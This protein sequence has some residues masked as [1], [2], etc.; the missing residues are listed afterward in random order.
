MSGNQYLFLFTIGP[1]QSFIAQ[2]RKTRDLYAGSKILE[3]IIGV[4][5]KYA[6]KNYHAEIIIPDSCSDAKPNRFLAKITNDDP[7]KFAEAVENAA[8]DKWRDI[9]LQ[10]FRN[11]GVCHA[12]ETNGFDEVQKRRIDCTK[13]EQIKPA[14]AG[15]QIEDFLEVYWVMLELDDGDDY[16]EKHDEI[17]KLLAAIKNTRRFNQIDEPAARKCSLDGERNVLF[18]HPVN[19]EENNGEIEKELRKKFIQHEPANKCLYHKNLNLGEGLS[20]VSFVKRFYA[21]GEAFPSTAKVALIDVLQE[22]DESSKASYKERFQKYEYFDEQLYYEENLTSD[23]FRKRGFDDLIPDLVALEAQRKELFEGKKQPRYYALIAFDGDDMGKVWSGETLADKESLDEFQPE[24]SSLLQ[25][26]QELLAFRLG[27]YAAYATAYLDGG[28]RES[29]DG[30]PEKDIWRRVLK[31]QSYQNLI[32]RREG[33]TQ[34][35]YESRLKLSKTEKGRTVYAGGD[36]FLGFINLHY[37]FDVMN[38]LRAAYEKLVYEP[39]VEND[40]FRLKKPLTFSAGVVIAHYKEPLSIVLNEAHVAESEAKR[41]FK[42]NDKDAFAISVL[43]HSGESRKCLFK[44][45]NNDKYLTQYQDEIVSLLNE[46]KGFSNT[47]IKN[48]DKEFSS[49]IGDIDEYKV[50]DLFEVELKRLIERS[51]KRGNDK[52]VIKKMMDP[53]MSVCDSNYEYNQPFEN[54]FSAL[55]VCDFIKRKTANE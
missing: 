8:R 39:L 20:S 38:E 23:G 49:L 35:A 14:E 42:K 3:D 16:Q 36:D 13:L 4:A 48:I 40:I 1:V 27:I 7:K 10:S 37:L 28:I 29:E 41:V 51:S 32:Q 44:W 54:I 47:F 50:V 55:H 5:M 26:F 6:Q 53:V 33:E 34:E 43:K 17:Q 22:I 46:K 30:L 25:Q 21:K 15:K 9:A 2:A 31:D 18:Y 12:P 19:D 24:T 45:K 52:D 11:A